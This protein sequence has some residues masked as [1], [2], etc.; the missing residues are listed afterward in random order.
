[1][2]MITTAIQLIMLMVLFSI[3]ESWWPAAREHKWWQRPLLVDI[4]SWLAH[5]LSVSAGIALAVAFNDSILLNLFRFSPTATELRRSL[6]AI[7]FYVQLSIGVVIVDFIWYWLHRAYHQFSVLWA[8]HLIHHSSEKLDWLS[9]SRLHPLGQTLDHAAITIVLLL[10][11]FPVSVV[12]ASNVVIGAGAVVTHANVP[13]TFGLLRHILVSPVFHQWHHARTDEASHQHAA[14]NFGALFSF[15]DR[16]F[17][18]CLVPASNRPDHFGVKDAPTT[19][20]KL[21]FHPIRVCAT[22]FRSAFLSRKR[23]RAL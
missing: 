5:P 23:K 6:A 2:E 10:L 1:M 16:L 3:I 11:G 12:V 4:C 22:T 18:S 7:P 14:G 13:W 19:I 20:S 15:W 21:F 17:G 8:F 9:T